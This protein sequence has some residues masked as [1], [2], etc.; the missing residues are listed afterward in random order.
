M[1]ARALLI[2]AGLVGAVWTVAL[3]AQDSLR[4]DAA[5]MERKLVAIAARGERQPAQAPKPLRTSFT[6][7]E[8][9]AYFKVHGAEVV[10]EGLIDPQLTIDDDG[11]VRAKAIVD[12]DTTVKP[13]QR[14]WLDPLAWVSGKV[15]MTAV[16]RLQ[17]SAG[18]GRFA[19]ESATLGGVSVPAT[20]VQELLSYYS[21][22]PERPAGFSL[23]EPFDLPAKIRT[24]ETVRG[25]A[26]VVQ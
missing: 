20:L 14:T 5:S 6:D 2:S 22:S 25:L 26:T 1:T 8:V 16:G 11:R 10:P 19:I 24:V 7:R 13:K 18:K 12:L 23:N 4:T 17:T 21:R 9:N 15:E 3:P